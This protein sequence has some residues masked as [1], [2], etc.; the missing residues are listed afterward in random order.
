MS[1]NRCRRTYTAVSVEIDRVNVLFLP[2]GAKNYRFAVFFRKAA[3]VDGIGFVHCPRLIGIQIPADKIV[4]FARQPQ[5]LCGRQRYLGAVN[6]IF[7]LFYKLIAV[8]KR[9]GIRNRNPF[10]KK[11]KVSGNFVFIRFS[12]SVCLII[13]RASAVFR[14]VKPAEHISRSRG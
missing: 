12:R 11:G 8:V 10:C 7:R 1:H 9:Y 4:V 5:S 13:L 2:S 6:H 14:R 3:R